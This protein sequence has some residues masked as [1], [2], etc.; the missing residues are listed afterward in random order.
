MLSI[1]QGMGTLALG[2]EY[3]LSSILIL[4]RPA[5]GQC[6]DLCRIR[7]GIDQ[8]GDESRKWIP[9]CNTQFDQPAFMLLCRRHASGPHGRK[10]D[11][12]AVGDRQCE[13]P[14]ITP[15]NLGFA[16]LS[17]PPRCTRF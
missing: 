16:F 13:L 6:G 10:G 17:Q 5:A 9:V 4:I 15:A 8:A 1:V 2:V 11:H 14:R 12:I 3:N 7:G